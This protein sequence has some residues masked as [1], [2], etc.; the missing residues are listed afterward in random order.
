MKV[1]K[2]V[3]DLLGNNGID[4]VFGQIGGFNADLL[5]AIAGSKKQR[6]VLNYHEQGAAFA[7]NAFAM[8]RE[9]VSAATSS[10][11][12]S[13]CNL[14]AGIAN[15]FFDS[16]P[17]LFLV[18]SVHSEA[19]KKSPEVRQNAFEEMDM[20]ALTAGITKYAVKINDAKD[21]RFCLE[22]ALHIA[23]EGR[24]GP[25][26]ID[27]PYDVARSDINVEELRGYTPEGAREFDKIDVSQILEALQ[28]AKRPLLLLGGGCRNESTR[29]A[30][31]QFLDK[32]PI[33]AVASL[34]GLDVLPHE[35][36]SFVGF[37]GHYG[38]R[39]ANFA[40]ANCDC[41]IILGSRLDERQLAGDKTRFA[42]EAK[43]IRVDIDRTELDRVQP[44]SGKGN[45]N[46]YSSAGNFLEQMLKADL[47][48]LSFPKWH[49]V[50][51]R[52]KARYPSH[53][54]SRREVDAN[55]FLHAISEDLPSE[56]VVCADVGQNQMFTAQ[57]F[58]LR[59]GNR[60]LNTGGYGSMGFSLP[61]S[62]GAAYA[63]PNAMV[64]SINGDGGLMM[65]IQE[66]QAVKRDKLPIKIIVLNNNC[67]GMIRRLQE[68]IFDDRTTGSVEGYEAPDYSAIAPSYGLEYIRIDAVE[69][70]GLV[71]ELL[72]SPAAMIIEVELPTR[73]MNNPEPGAAID[74][75]TPL[76]SDE[77][78]RQIKRDCLF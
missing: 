45:I 60:L 50:I 76:L 68:R 34:C 35:H 21:V 64:I 70:Y 19:V 14:V 28:N 16:I 18:G 4:I 43:I 73:I 27:L 30:I 63:W 7:A 25:V 67:L 1:A 55:D 41:L 58:R 23:R 57:S 47:R 8:V 49:A 13:S 52:W 24:K 33:P 29:N 44:G 32:A 36:P 66:L 39:Y 65:N 62:I 71:R 40:L 46:L 51:A 38:N 59:K 77:E 10:G 20:V 9:N 12:P 72:K 15:A 53:H 61:A 54:T 5:D 48:Q 75:Q 22:K 6:F 74:L 3:V 2:Y 31:L 42:G 56:L 17:C 78:N 11:A 26:L 69:K 37:I